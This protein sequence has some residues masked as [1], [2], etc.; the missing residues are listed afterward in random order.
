MPDYTGLMKNPGSGKDDAKFYAMV[1]TMAAHVDG[2]HGRDAL[3]SSALE[4]LSRAVVVEERLRARCRDL[5]V[6]AA[7]RLRAD[8]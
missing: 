8:W 6:R 3:V 5:D 1:L 2:A 4:R 7:T